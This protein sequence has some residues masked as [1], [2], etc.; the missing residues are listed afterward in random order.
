LRVVC[1]DRLKHDGYG[2]KEIFSEWGQNS[3][4]P[5]LTRDVAA[6]RRTGSRRDF[7]AP[8]RAALNGGRVTARDFKKAHGILVKPE[9]N[10]DAA[11]DQYNK[12]I[13]RSIVR[14]TPTPA[15]GQIDFI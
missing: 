9:G 3:N 6:R 11:V 10:G 15:A 5:L 13:R 14:G 2:V 7:V 4:R 12:A 1:N 8:N